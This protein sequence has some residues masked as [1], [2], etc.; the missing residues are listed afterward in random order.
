MKERK[1]PRSLLIPFR[2]VD[3]CSSRN[4]V[5]SGCCRSADRTTVAGYPAFMS[6]PCSRRMCAVRTISSLRHCWWLGPWYHLRARSMILA[7]GVIGLCRHIYA[8]RRCSMQSETASSRQGPRWCLLLGLAL[9]AQGG[10]CRF[11]VPLERYRCAT[12][13]SS[14]WCLP[15]SDIGLWPRDLRAAL[16][17]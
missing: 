1:T 4:R 17:R 12:V 14:T 6:A 5:M 2:E 9:S 10:C 16:R 11:A 7:L 13:V 8:R 15:V 3:P